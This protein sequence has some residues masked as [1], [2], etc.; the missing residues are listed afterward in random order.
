VCG[1]QGSSAWMVGIERAD[2]RERARGRQALSA[3][4]VWDR[5]AG[6]RQRGRW[7]VSSTHGMR[8]ERPGG[9]DQGRGQ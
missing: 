3:H 8:N 6:G 1:Q 7:R 5:A 2:D 4:G 9:E